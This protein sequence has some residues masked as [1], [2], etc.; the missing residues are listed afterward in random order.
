MVLNSEKDTDRGE[1]HD[2][3]QQD[4]RGTPILGET[5]EPNSN[6][7]NY[8]HGKEQF[9]AYID[10]D[11]FQLS[12]KRILKMHETSSQSFRFCKFP[13]RVSCNVFLL[14]TFSEGF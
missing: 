8:L 14:L 4:N 13:I 7:E 6:I 12:T 2:R 3:Q 5:T 1:A 11:I 10:N 9:H